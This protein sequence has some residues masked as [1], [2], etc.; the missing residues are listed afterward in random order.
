MV[1]LGLLLKANV[2]QRSCASGHYRSPAQGIYV[3]E[4]MGRSSVY[5][6]ISSKSNHWFSFAVF[7]LPIAVEFSICLICRGFFCLPLTSFVFRFALRR[8]CLQPFLRH[9]NRLVKLL[10][11]QFAFRQFGHIFCYLN[12]AF[13]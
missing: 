3:R 6:F 4:S 13:I 2:F 7:S 9:F 8:F 11:Q 10:F 5:K 1:R 12:T